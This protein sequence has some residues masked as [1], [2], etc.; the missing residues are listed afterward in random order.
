MLTIDK[1]YHGIK[2]VAASL[3]QKDDEYYVYLDKKIY[4]GTNP[5]DIEILYTTLPY[6]ALEEGTFKTNNNSGWVCHNT[7]DNT[8]EAYSY[9]GDKVVTLGIPPQNGYNSYTYKNGKWWKLNI[10]TD[11]TQ[12]TGYEKINTNN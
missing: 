12:I 8:H 2:Y 9:T 10:L 4:K 11:P 7:T 1:P 5:L 3:I 6:V